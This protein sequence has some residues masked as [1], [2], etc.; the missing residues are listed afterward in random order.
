MLAQYESEPEPRRQEFFFHA[1][2]GLFA[3]NYKASEGTM[4]RKMG[5][6]FGLGYR[7]ALSP[8]WS[9][10]TGMELS[11][12]SNAFQLDHN[13]KTS[14]L[15]IDIDSEQFEFRNIISTYEEKQQI[16]M[17]QIPAMLHYLT[18][19][20]YQFYMALGAKIGFPITQHY[21]VAP[22]TIKNSG[23]YEQEHYEY[24]A[25]EIVGFG[26]FAT[27]EVDGNFSFKP[28]WFAAAESGIKLPLGEISSLYVGLFM[29]YGLTNMRSK[30]AVVP[31]IIE[32]NAI[33]PRQFII[34]SVLQSSHASS[35]QTTAFTDKVAPMAIGIK[36]RLVF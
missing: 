5:A 23:Y 21:Q 18:Q 32:Y 22:T 30:A 16:V 31:P 35:G 11:L 2:P 25:P 15:A 36:M 17:L 19:G 27:E 20:Y 33:N 1:A 3:L 9:L 29:D 24:E 7:Y 8:T 26:T 34:N 13:F 14:S 28:A 4:N 12:Y 10:E 6:Q